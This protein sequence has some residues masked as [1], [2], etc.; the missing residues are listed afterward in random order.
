MYIPFP[1]YPPYPPLTL[2]PVSLTHNFTMWRAHGAYSNT[3]GQERVHGDYS[4]TD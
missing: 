1:L 2:L 3:E 4:N